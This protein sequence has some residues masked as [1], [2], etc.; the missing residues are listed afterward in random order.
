MPWLGVCPFSEYGLG[1]WTLHSWISYPHYYRVVTGLQ[2]LSCGEQ[3]MELWQLSQTT[4]RCGPPRKEGVDHPRGSRAVQGTAGRRD[5]LVP[6]MEERENNWSC[7]SA[8][9]RLLGRSLPSTANAELGRGFLNWQWRS[10]KLMIIT[11]ANF[12]RALPRHRA[13]CLTESSWPPCGVWCSSF[14]CWADEDSRT[15]CQATQLVSSR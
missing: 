3:V 14:L 9:D 15:L 12:S 2:T 5:S 11:T 1:F 7:P 4:L 10:W 13:V 6:W 8:Y